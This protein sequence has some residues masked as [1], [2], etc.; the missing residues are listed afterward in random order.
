MVLSN[1]QTSPTWKHTASSLVAHGFLFVSGVSL[2]WALLSF[3][4]HPNPNFET[5]KTNPNLCYDPPQTT[6]YDDP[7]LS[8]DIERPMKDW[9]MKR[10]EWFKHHPSFNA[11]LRNRILIVTGSQPSKCQ[12]QVGDHLLLRLFKN[13]VDYSRLHGYDIFYNNALLHPKM[14]GFWAKY[15]LIRAAML[16]HPE[17]EWIWWIDSD[18]MFTDMEFKIP[19]ERYENH[20]LVVHGWKHL[21]Y[22]KQSW[23]SVNAGVFL[24]RNCQWSMDFMQAWASMGPQTQNYDKWGRIQKSTFKDKMFPQSD[25][26]SALIYLLLNKNERAK[27]E[28]KIYV[29]SEYSLSGYWLGIVDDLTNERGAELMMG[30]CRGA[31]GSWRRPFVTHF[32][33]CEP[34]SG[35]HNPMY[36]WEACWKGMLKALNFA[37]NQV[38]STFG[39][40]HPDL[41]NSSWVS[42]RA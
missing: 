3:V 18:A 32:T 21:I 13:K 14:T 24:M 19:L 37:D 39:F 33:G 26:Q 16:A 25:D 41:L 6:F 36:T 7:H 20:N 34:C 31:V 23:T 38:L 17:A 35:D 42:R 12:N 29:E 27:W 4:Y 11:G 15:P 10:R 9:D 40:V 5:F 2:V 22:S 30:D 1:S 28:D 8:Y